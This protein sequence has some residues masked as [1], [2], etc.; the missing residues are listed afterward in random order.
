MSAIVS[1]LNG[2]LRSGGTG[3]GGP[4][5]SSIGAAIGLRR[6]E[7]PRQICRPIGH[8][9]LR[10][11]LAGRHQDRVPVQ[12]PGDDLVVA[13]TGRWCADDLPRE[14]GGRGSGGRNVGPG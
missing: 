13:A 11:Q 2:N 8:E 7:R 1:R 14:G 3:R 5:V 6:I 4:R 9:I 12:Q 10:D